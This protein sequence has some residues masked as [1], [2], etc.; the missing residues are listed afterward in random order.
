MPDKGFSNVVRLHDR[1]YA[2]PLAEE[3]RLDLPFLPHLGV[4]NAP[5]LEACKDILDDLNAE[6]FEILGRVESLEVIGFDGETVWSIE[7]IQLLGAEN[8]AP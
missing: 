6:A 5:T 2:G 1:L 3:L 7:E 4:A 8:A